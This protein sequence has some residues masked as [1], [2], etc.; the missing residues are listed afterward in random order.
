MRASMRR[1]TLVSTAAAA[2]V[3]TVAPARAD[4]PP[5]VD[6]P[7]PAPACS[8]ALV[9]E[10]VTV[11]RPDTRILAESGSSA[12][13]SP[14]VE[15]PPASGIRVREVR[16]DVSPGS[17]VLRLDLTDARA[18]A[19]TV[20]LTGDGFRCSGDLTLRQSA[21]DARSGAPG[22]RGPTGGR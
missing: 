14:E 19:W 3:L 5:A 20:T 18:G 13:G 15:V 6:R 9:P 7:E 16:P 12:R 10:A 2:A 4:R 21:R 11:G 17:W 8:V 22:V 1:R